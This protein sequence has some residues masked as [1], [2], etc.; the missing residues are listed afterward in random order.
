MTELEALVTLNLLPNVGPVRVRRLL[1]NL[2]SP[3]A[4]LQATTSQLLTTPGIGDEIALHINSWSDLTDVG[5]ELQLARQMGA[6]ILTAADPHYPEPLRTIYD[7]P[8]V[9]YT[10]GQLEPADR[11][12]VSI[13]GSR[14]TTT[15]GQ[16]VA[17]KFS[18]QLARAGMT[19]V[20]GLARGI[21]TLA[22]EAAI[23]AKGRTVAVLGSGLA[24]LY[25]PE[26]RALAD[27]IASGHGAVVSEFPINTAPD[28]QTFPQRNRIVAA[29]SQATL[30]VEAP[31][32]S[33][34]LITANLANEYNRS[35]FAIPGP[36]D[37]PTAQGCNT[38]IQNGARLA[39]DPADI[40]DDI[41]GLFS[42]QEL[43]PEP[44]KPTLPPLTGDEKAIFEALGDEET[45]IDQV[46]SRT[47]LTTSTVST[48]LLR[49]QMKRL[50]K[51]LPGS[52]FVKLL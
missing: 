10:L 7:S 50:V 27:L 9:L 8:I 38:L 12:A 29:W 43:Q 19:I 44:L 32:K 41:G 24:Q 11:H 5:G 14:R 22:H 36:I 40:L 20:S 39:T 17:K 49:L 28:R 52:R 3:Q 47:G 1:D 4:I 31:K 46:V 33:G 16:N 51:Q 18:F 15:Y 35:V 37:R 6:T 21:D 23:A 26:N 13:V 48:T 45:P 30:V 25:P 42:S 34:S 2:G